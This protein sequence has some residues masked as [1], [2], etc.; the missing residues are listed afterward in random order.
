MI[1]PKPNTP[2]I[3]K[4]KNVVRLQVVRANVLNTDHFGLSASFRYR[5]EMIQYEKQQ[6]QKTD[7]IDANTKNVHFCKRKQA[8]R[9]R[10]KKVER[11]EK[12]EKKEE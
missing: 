9:R 10:G 3:I 6:Q 11:K 7:S 1:I 12:R 4:C 8:L 2:T 5:F